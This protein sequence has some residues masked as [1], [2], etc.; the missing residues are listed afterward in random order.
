[1]EGLRDF[2][3]NI[4]IEIDFIEK[5]TKI[6]EQFLRNNSDEILKCDKKTFMA[7]V[8]P[9]YQLKHEGGAYYTITKT[10]DKYEFILEIHKTSG[11][12]LLFYI[13]IYRDG[14]LQNVD[15]SPVGSVL[16]YLPYDKSRIEKTNRTF[17]YNTLSEMKDY[18]TQMITLWEEFVEK[19]IEKLELGIEPPNTP[20]ED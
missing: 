20:Y 5:I 1:M 19:Y 6:R 13:Y 17:G 8:D 4:L 10:Y 11:A 14:V 12:G 7:M 2:E 9:Q 18:L 3:K 16:Y 15:L